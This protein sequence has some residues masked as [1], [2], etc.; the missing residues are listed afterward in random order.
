MEFRLGDDYKPWTEEQ[1]NA[2]MESLESELFPD[3]MENRGRSGGTV[4]SITRI[5]GSGD[6]EKYKKV[7]GEWEQVY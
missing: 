2:F 5:N 1:V 3:R 4:T 6:K 7:D